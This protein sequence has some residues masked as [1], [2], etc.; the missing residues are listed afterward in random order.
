MLINKIPTR[1]IDKFNTIDKWISD[2]NMLFN[3][4]NDYF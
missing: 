3:I 4:I 2:I 1:I